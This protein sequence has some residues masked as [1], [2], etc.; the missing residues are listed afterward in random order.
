MYPGFS[1]YSKPNLRKDVTKVIAKSEER[2]G[3]P[4]IDQIRKLSVHNFAAQGPS[5]ARALSRKILGNEEFCLQIDSHNQFVQDWD[6]KLKMEWSAAENEFGI[7]S[8][9]P[10]G[11]YELEHNK[12]QTTVAR[13]CEIEFQDNKVPVRIDSSATLYTVSLMLDS[14]GCHFSISTNE[15]MERLRI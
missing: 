10:L 13:G 8:A 5:W 1:I 7:I 2:Q 3:C 9:P 11:Y 4:R 6:E 12:D 14:Y 15:E